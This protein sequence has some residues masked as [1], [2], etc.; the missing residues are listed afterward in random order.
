MTLWLHLHDH[1]DMAACVD[2]PSFTIGRSTDC[3]WVLDG[4]SVSRRHAV[5]RSINGVYL[6]EDTSRNGTRLN[7]RVLK[8]GEPAPL[9]VGDRLR[10]DTLEIVVTDAKP[11]IAASIDRSEAIPSLRMGGPLAGLPEA[12]GDTKAIR[13]QTSCW[14]DTPPLIEAPT[15]A[16]RLFDALLDELAPARFEVRSRNGRGRRASE[17]AW[18][19]YHRHFRRIQVDPEAYFRRLIEALH[20]TGR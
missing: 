15:A 2:S 19:R 20:E 6:I 13:T 5:I 10:I 14:P 1:P 9:A 11:D 12:S 3:H 17:A 8:A 7:D 4:G 16:R 18:G